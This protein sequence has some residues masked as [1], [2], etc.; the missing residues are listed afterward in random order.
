MPWLKQKATRV[1]QIIKMS[2][3]PKL[4]INTKLL[5]IQNNQLQHHLHA[6]TKEKEIVI[7]CL[8][9][10]EVLFRNKYEKFYSRKSSYDTQVRHI[11]E[12]T[13]F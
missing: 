11:E 4:I 2:L 9:H 8:K 1:V 10:E 12:T 13:N 6:L 3:N 5:Q 7:R